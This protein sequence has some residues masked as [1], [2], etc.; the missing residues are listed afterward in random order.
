MACAFCAMQQDLQMC[1][2][3][4]R[5]VLNQLEGPTWFKTRGFEP[6]GG[7]LLCKTYILS[8]LVSLAAI[9]FTSCERAIKYS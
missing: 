1:Q 4:K 9:I 8:W 2:F 5:R 6:A 7:F 3:A